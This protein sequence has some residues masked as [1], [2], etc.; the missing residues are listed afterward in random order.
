[1]SEHDDEQEAAAQRDQAQH[2][3]TN[4]YVDVAKLNEALIDVFGERGIRGTSLELEIDEAY[5][6]KFSDDP[7]SGNIYTYRFGFETKPGKAIE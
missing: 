3:T 1:M 5:W 2:F 6:R 4:R 7:W